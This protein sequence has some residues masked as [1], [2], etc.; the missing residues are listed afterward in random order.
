MRTRCICA[1]IVVI[2]GLVVGLA[3]TAS[4][5]PSSVVFETRWGMSLTETDKAD[6]L[7][8][9]AIV[10]E[11]PIR[12]VLAS[13]MLPTSI[14]FIR[15]SYEEEVIG[16]WVIETSLEIRRRD[17]RDWAQPYLDS[18]DIGRGAWATKR[19]LFRRDVLRQFR[20]DGSEI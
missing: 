16:T 12:K 13:T 15:V 19:E 8:I 1:V 3:S 7:G 18:L 11:R 10:S 9:A 20:I 5:Q 2:G 14:P 17:A 6:I 4:C